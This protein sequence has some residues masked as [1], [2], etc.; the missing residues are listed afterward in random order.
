MTVKLLTEQHLEFLSLKGG[1]TGLYVSTLV[2]MPHCLKSHVT[3]QFILIFVWI[4]H[5]QIKN[6]KHFNET[7][8]ELEG[9]SRTNKGITAAFC[10][11]VSKATVSKQAFN[12][13]LWFLQLFKTLWTAIIWFDRYLCS[14]TC[15]TCFIP[16]IHSPVMTNTLNVK[17][18]FKQK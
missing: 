14:L 12:K 3:A 10:F 7:S 11:A 13:S 18:S 17:Q 1:C 5:V 2:K 4:M 16:L 9:P 6:N 15:A 8:S